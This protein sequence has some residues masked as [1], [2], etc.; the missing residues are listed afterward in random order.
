MLICIWESMSLE[1]FA[2]EILDRERTDKVFGKRL[3]VIAHVL[4]DDCRRLPC[5]F[6]T[7][8]QYVRLFAS[9]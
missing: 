8:I 3:L 5:R 2:C 9:D 4:L 1:P 7:L 6:H